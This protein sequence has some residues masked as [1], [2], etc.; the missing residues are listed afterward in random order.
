MA[1]AAG[2]EE[3]SDPLLRRELDTAARIS[4]GE[5]VT[6]LTA[7]DD[8]EEDDPL[9]RRKQGDFSTRGATPLSSSAVPRKETW[10]A[11]L[12]KSKLGSLALVRSRKVRLRA[13]LAAL[14]EDL[15][16][17]E[18]TLAAKARNSKSRAWV[19][20]QLSRDVLLWWQKGD[21][22]RSL[23]AACLLA[24]AIA[25]VDEPSEYSSQW[26]LVI[27]A[28][29]KI[30]DLLKSHLEAQKLE[31]P[32]EASRW[33]WYY[34]ISCIRGLV[35]RLYL[36][37]ATWDVLSKSDEVEEGARLFAQAQGISNPVVYQYFCAYLSSKKL[38]GE[39]QSFTRDVLQSTKYAYLTHATSLD[40]VGRSSAATKKSVTS[41]MM[42]LPLSL[43]LCNTIDQVQH[44]EK[45]FPR[46][47]GY[48]RSPAALQALLNV[49]D[50]NVI[51]T[52]ALQVL[53]SIEL[54][55]FTMRPFCIS[56]LA[57]KLLLC[58]PPLEESQAKAA[59]SSA[60]LILKATDE[61]LAE[62]QQQQYPEVL[63]AAV[64]ASAKFLELCARSYGIK[65]V[66]ALIKDLERRVREAGGSSRFNPAIVRACSAICDRVEKDPVRFAP[67]ISGEAFGRLFESLAN[68]YDASSFT[69]SSSPK[70][71]LAKRLLDLFLDRD[72]QK[73]D[74]VAA[75]DWAK[76]L[77]DS[78]HVLT[79][80][81]ERRKVND[82]V[83]RFAMKTLTTIAPTLPDDA[84]FALLADLRGRFFHSDATIKLLVGAAS[85]LARSTRKREIASSCLA[86][87]HAT[88]PSI[89]DPVD[90][91]MFYAQTAVLAASL[92]K[93]PQC[94][95]LFKASVQCVADACSLAGNV[96]DSGHKHRVTENRA[97]ELVRTVASSLVVAPGHPHPM[98]LVKGFFNAVQKNAQWTN[99]EAFLAVLVLVEVLLRVRLPY[100]VAGADSNDVL[101]GDD[102]TN[103]SNDALVMATAIEAKLQSIYPSQRDDCARL[104]KM[105]ATNIELRSE[106]VRQRQ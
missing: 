37:A 51:G 74:F 13:R 64:S 76:S 92:G 94:D 22:S 66:S 67:L 91:G 78:L 98:Y 97:L 42:V 53:E 41:E 72:S 52:C 101:F 103:Y 54:F 33:N 35:V 16:E 57:D 77:N 105:I 55:Q 48:C 83:R 84:R 50:P 89:P 95:G 56:S 40:V 70:T 61:T 104:M 1:T 81:D 3:Q 75:A 8:D 47:A 99:G 17:D 44:Q 100:R 28:L 4:G 80:E 21:R 39:A 19:L 46:L 25:E 38:V 45:D 12:Q 15:E 34:K 5:Q 87:C 71:D 32:D 68:S 24:G 7:G 90:R 93:L 36:Q 88:I 9:A 43:T 27:N 30:H 106:Q 49:T 65:E 23:R 31:E 102:A 60:W 20:E 26:V 82:Y 18:D 59:M 10:E 63:N 2:D 85:A 29:N 14:R 58:D 73:I 6:I 62:L 86:F 96:N 11:L 79:F 69:Q